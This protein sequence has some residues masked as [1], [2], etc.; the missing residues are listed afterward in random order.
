MLDVGNEEVTMQNI[1]ELGRVI[2]DKQVRY[3]HEA[4]RG[5]FTSHPVRRWIGTHLVQFGE[6]ILGQDGDQTVPSGVDHPPR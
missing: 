1:D 4:Y 5:R 6:S 2:R 3:R